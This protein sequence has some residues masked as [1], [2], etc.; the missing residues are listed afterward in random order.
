[1]REDAAPRQWRLPALLGLALVATLPV[2]AVAGVVD[3]AQEPLYTTTS[4]SVKPNL[5]FILDNSGSMLDPAYP[6]E[7]TTQ[8]FDDSFNPDMPYAGKVVLATVKGDIHDLGKNIVSALLS[9]SG[10]AVVDLGKDVAPEAILASVQ[11]EK[12]DVLGLC[13]LMTTTLGSM[14][15]TI[16]LLHEQGEK[17]KIMVGGAVL[18]ADYA[19]EIKADMYAADG[20]QA[21]RL[22]EKA[23]NEEKNK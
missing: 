19:K 5:M 17:V 12:P 2:Y 18:T 10:F 8:C 9:N 23:V 4:S 13:A 21:V 6:L 1:M 15:E 16:K 7:K 3:L 20:V 22:A 11:K 14:E